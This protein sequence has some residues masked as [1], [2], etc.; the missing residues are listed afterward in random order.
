M[1]T[2]ECYTSILKSMSIYPDEQGLLSMKIAE[3]CNVICTCGDLRLAL[4]TPER[5]N[6]GDWSGL[7]AF[8]PLSESVLCGESPV[9]KRLRIYALTRVSAVTSVLI[10]TLSELASDKE[11]H[12]T[13][14][15]ALKDLLVK[16][17]DAKKKT[18]ELIFKIVDRS[19][20]VETN[21]LISFFIKRGAAI[22]GSSYSRGC[23]TTFPIISELTP[24][25][26]N[27]FGVD[28]QSSTKTARVLMGILEY[29]FPN[30]DT[31]DTYSFGSNSMEVPN[32]HALLGGYLAVAKALNKITKK[33][34]KH[35]PDYE[36]WII[37]T[38]WES[39]L[40]NLGSFRLEIPAL[41]GNVGSCNTDSVDGAAAP[42]PVAASPLVGGITTMPAVAPVAAKPAVAIAAP[43]GSVFNTDS[44]KVGRVEVP[45]VTA[46]TGF[47][48]SYPQPVSTPA[49]VS[50]VAAQ[51]RPGTVSFDAV[52]RSNPALATSVS[53]YGAPVPQA[54]IASAGRAAVSQRQAYP[55][56]GQ[57]QYGQPQYAQPV[58]GFGGF[59]NV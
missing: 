11:L 2:I 35:I 56:Y 37:D 50:H 46:N 32:L 39:Y 33:F 8:H 6:S 25:C 24:G 58:A 41:E 47:V 51:P 3:D 19:S 18:N 57:P 21:R 49:P 30:I 38:D 29:I 10:N 4:P 52:M 48:T 23:I 36:Q 28:V 16:V 55:Q 1:R 53:G 54:P 15:P 13:M 5:I 14:A 27:I 59:G 34:K 44:F 17:P 20:I 42:A 12:K 7:M 22:D 31:K 43:T 26:K 9:L 45:Q 40:D